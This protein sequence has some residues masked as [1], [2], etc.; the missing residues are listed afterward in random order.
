MFTGGGN[1]EMEDVE[2]TTVLEL[3]YYAVLDR[4]QKL[5]MSCSA[6]KISICFI[7][8]NVLSLLRKSIRSGSL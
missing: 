4:Y 6:S 1:F 8:E 3:L 7:I 2:Y 5:G